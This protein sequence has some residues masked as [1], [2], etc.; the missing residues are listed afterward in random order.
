[1]ESAFNVKDFNG[2]VI[3][4]DPEK[5]GTVIVDGNAPSWKEASKSLKYECRGFS[6]PASSPCYVP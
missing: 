2:K 4:Y 5:H 6:K 1:M 3:Y